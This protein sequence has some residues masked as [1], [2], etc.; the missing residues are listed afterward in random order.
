M[1]GV[2]GRPWKNKKKFPYYIRKSTRSAEWLKEI[3][4]NIEG[5]DKDSHQE[6]HAPGV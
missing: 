1:G 2:G 6:R 5:S 4:K 3:F